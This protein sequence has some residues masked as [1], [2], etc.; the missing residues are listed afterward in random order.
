M[1]PSAR[2]SGTEMLVTDEEIDEMLSRAEMA[3]EVTLP[4]EKF[5]DLCLQASRGAHHKVMAEMMAEHIWRTHGVC[6]K[7]E[8][9]VDA[10]SATSSSPAG[11]PC[12]GDKPGASGREVTKGPRSAGIGPRGPHEDEQSHD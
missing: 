12:L 4:I 6:L 8:V 1:K 2:G 10:L 11:D 5:R 3:S 7:V 9:L